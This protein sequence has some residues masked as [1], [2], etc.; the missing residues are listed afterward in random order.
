MRFIGVI[1]ISHKFYLGKVNTFNSNEEL[2]FAFPFEI[3]NLIL[4]F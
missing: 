2:D 3:M 1:I 4:F